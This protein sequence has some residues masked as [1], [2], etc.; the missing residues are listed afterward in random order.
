M[1]EPH[2][3]ALTPRLEVR[4]PTELDRT[5][6]VELFRDDAF[7]V[8]SGGA[9]TAD[10]AHARFDRM[11][12]RCRQLSFYVISD[13]AMQLIA[14]DDAGDLRSRARVW[15]WRDHEITLLTS[16]THSPLG[17]RTCSPEAFQNP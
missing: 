3:R 2:S 1:P 4:S 7:M 11:L 12:A 13:P 17:F 9:L 10:Q 8:F 16:R 5:R 15:R 6:F 14:S